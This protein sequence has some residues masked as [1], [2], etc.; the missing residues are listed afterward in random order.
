MP[1]EVRR[2]RIRPGEGEI[3]DMGAFTAAS[4]QGAGTPV[5]GDM[6]RRAA[7]GRN[8]P[9]GLPHAEYNEGELGPYVIPVEIQGIIY[10]Y[11]PPDQNTLGTGTVAE[12]TA[13]AASAPAPAAEPGTA[14]SAPDSAPAKPQ[15]TNPAAPPAK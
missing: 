2:V 3:L 13:E 5:R 1:I 7:S 6:A 15:D 14:P 4:T 10:I 12:K 11:N 8:I 9:G